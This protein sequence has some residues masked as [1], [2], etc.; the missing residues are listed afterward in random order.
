MVRR[1]RM[2]RS[3]SQK[4]WR[5][6]FFQYFKSVVLSLKSWSIH[7][8]CN[9][10]MPPT[11]FYLVWHQWL[12]FGFQKHLGEARHRPVLHLWG[13]YCI[14]GSQNESSCLGP[15]SLCT[16][17]PM[18]IPGGQI[19]LGCLLC[20]EELNKRASKKNRETNAEASD[21]CQSINL[22]SFLALTAGH[23]ALCST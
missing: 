10:F 3:T 6:H 23:K 5:F 16:P 19:E 2:D 8:F 22:C 7:E 12:R 14:L 11:V 21:G 1:A 20:S 9:H 13:L 18:A 15:A 17:A 4:S